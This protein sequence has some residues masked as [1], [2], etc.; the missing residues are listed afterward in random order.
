MA[1]QVL[2]FK[3]LKCPQPT[4]K[5]TSLTFKMPK[6]DVVEIT[7]DCPTFEA[8]VRGW[9]S[10]NKKIMLWIKNQGSGVKVCQIQF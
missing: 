10:R 4:L 2:D 5:L 7:A 8:D 6:G 3:G 9:C 1:L